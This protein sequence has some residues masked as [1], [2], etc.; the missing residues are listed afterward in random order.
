M[1]S[2]SRN[3]RSNWKIRVYF[4]RVIPRL[5]NSVMKAPI[6][7]KN[8]LSFLHLRVLTS[9]AVTK[10]LKQRQAS[11]VGMTEPWKERSIFSQRFF[12]FFKWG[13]PF[14]EISLVHHTLGPIS[15]WARKN[16]WS[17]KWQPT[18]VFFLGKFHG[19]RSPADYIVHG[20]SKNWTRLCDW[21][22]SWALNLQWRW[23]GYFCSTEY[24]LKSI[25]WVML[26]ISE[27]KTCKYFCL[28]GA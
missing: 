24:H 14:P 16:P 27:R 10:W 12:F 8:L 13:K 11:C 3:R 25:Y 21:A 20:V 19:Q 22:C 26:E 6:E 4:R 28:H 9:P 15:P 18:P 5:V 2:V 17:R 23:K 1:L 7:V